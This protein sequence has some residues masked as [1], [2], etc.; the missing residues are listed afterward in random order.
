[1][2]SHRD[3]FEEDNIDFKGVCCWC[4]EE[5][6]LVWELFH[7]TTCYDR[8]TDCVLLL[9]LNR[10][11]VQNLLVVRNIFL[12]LLNKCTRSFSSCA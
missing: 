4:Y 7:R 6:S 9:L 3:S 1:M 8:H 5:V 10:N 11:S 12:M 2:G